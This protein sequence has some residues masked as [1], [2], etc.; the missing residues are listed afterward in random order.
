MTIGRMLAVT[1]KL[2]RRSLRANLRRCARQVM[3]PDFTG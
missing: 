3:Q 2:D 1:G